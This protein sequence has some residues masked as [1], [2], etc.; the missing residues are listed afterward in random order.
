MGIRGGEGDM[1]VG[2]D[3]E[4]DTAFLSTLGMAGSKL[5]GWRMRLS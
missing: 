5:E 4:G 3:A 1:D 2:E